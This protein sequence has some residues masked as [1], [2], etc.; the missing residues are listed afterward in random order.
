MAQPIYGC[1]LF[2]SV[3]CG[4]FS[5][6]RQREQRKNSGRRSKKKQKKWMDGCF[7]SCLPLARH[8]QLSKK[9]GHAQTIPLRT[10]YSQDEKTETFCD[11]TQ[12]KKC[13]HVRTTRWRCTH[14]RMLVMCNPNFYACDLFSKDKACGHDSRNV[15]E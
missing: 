10:P 14:V 12:N 5:E 3:A 15:Y 1:L 4:T 8:G 2:L 11:K 9:G 13:S 7:I 6:A